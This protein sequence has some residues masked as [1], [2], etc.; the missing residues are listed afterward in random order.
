MSYP[1]LIASKGTAG[2]IATW[3]AYNNIDTVTVLEEAQSIIFQSLRIREMRTQYVFGLSAGQSK[4]ALPARFLDPIGRIRDNQGLYYRHKSESDVIANRSFQAVSGGSL[5]S[6]P[7][8]T[9]AINSSQFNVTIANHGLT[10]GSD[11]TLAGLTSP[12]DGINVNGTFPVEA[13]VDVNTITCSSP[14]GDEAAA[15]DV[16]GG[17]ASGAWSGNLLIETLPGIWSIFDEAIQFDGAFN[18]AVQCRLP[19][20]RSP[21]LLST[22]NPTNFLTSRFPSLVR[23]ATCAAAAAYMKDDT[24]E[25][26]WLQKLSLLVDATNVESDLSY[27][28]AEFGT[29]TPGAGRYDGD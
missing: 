24:E 29:D 28:G 23:T 22:T 3:V 1:S 4:I 5:G 9:G 16:T 27:R 7:I 14:L 11:V 15:G 6:N 2:A 10:Q 12:I 19:Y 20:F 26:K 8:T 17:G 13:V 18:Q 21:P 25:Q